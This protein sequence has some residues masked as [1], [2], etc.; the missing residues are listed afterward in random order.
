MS[1]ISEQA[2]ASIR[3]PGTEARGPGSPLVQYD[4][5]CR[6][7]AEAKTFDEVRN[8]RDEMEHVKLYGRRIKDRE[9]IAEATELQ[10]RASRRLGQL[11]DE[12]ERLGW[13]GQGRPKKT[14]PASEGFRLQE[15]GIDYKTS[16]ES[17]KLSALPDEDFEIGVKAVRE[18]VA[19]GGA[20]INGARA[21]MSSR[22]EPADGL[23]YFPTPPIATRA[24]LQHVF[25][26]LNRLGHCKFQKVWEPACGEGHMAEVLGEY[27]KH[28]FAT[29][30]HDYG[31][32]PHALADFLKF[33]QPIATDWIIT[34]PPFG[35][36]AEQFVLKSLKLAGTG[37]AIFA[38]LQWLES[39]GRYERLFSKYPPTLIAFFAERIPIWKGQWNPDGGTA[40]AYIWLVWLKGAAPQAPFWIPPGCKERL[41]KPDDIAR[42]T[43]HPVQKRETKAEAS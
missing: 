12:A 43:K 5:L 20:I 30:V 8:L 34:N 40:T 14:L 23:D 35:D 2:L 3:R 17:R 42:F 27:F 21:I 32:S 16:S 26:H 6:M 41:S 19:A 1:T 24:L 33:N 31:Y 25:P 37:V 10:A 18:K 7:I 28:V 15:A 29:D 11:L 38:R 4:T 39:D 13:I 36:K 9:L 22:N